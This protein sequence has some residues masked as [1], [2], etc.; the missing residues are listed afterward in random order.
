MQTDKFEVSIRVPR[1]ES[2][3]VSDIAKVTAKV[4]RL[5]LIT[6]LIFKETLID[7]IDQW[8][9]TTEI[10]KKTLTDS[11]FDFNIGDLA[12]AQGDKDLKKILKN[13]GIYNLVIEIPGAGELESDQWQFDSLLFRKLP[14]NKE[15]DVI[16]AD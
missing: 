5:E 2:G 15:G 3:Y 16:Y 1:Y 6:P 4:N 13:V 11:C 8:I 9:E 12:I 7:V 14:V 10:G